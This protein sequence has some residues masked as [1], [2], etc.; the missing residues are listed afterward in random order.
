MKAIRFLLAA[1][2][3]LLLLSGCGSQAAEAS[4][5]DTVL[6]TTYPMYYLTNRLLEG[7]EGVTAELMISEPVSCL[8]D[9]TLTTEEMKKIERADLIVMNGA[10]LEDF[11]QTA[12]A[13][14][15]EEN[16]IAA[17]DQASGDPHYWLSPERYLAAC[18][19]ISNGLNEKYP[20][21]SALLRSNQSSLTEELAALQ[22]NL[23]AKLNGLSCRKLIT[24]HDG[25]SCFAQAFDLEILASIEEEEGAEPSAAELKEICDLVEEYQIPAIFV[26]KNGSASAAEVIARET[27]VKIY[28]LNTIMDGQTDYITAMEG[29]IQA[30]KE[31]LS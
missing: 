13:Q 28:T 18:N 5:G 9:Y 7:A 29:N 25:F 26:E 22:E 23:N 31:A 1:A 21:Q 2:M 4:E 8:H 14:T 27:G 11:M 24:F 3:T 20:A 30:V 16:I 15:P 19:V 17:Q 10:G 6:C 12:L